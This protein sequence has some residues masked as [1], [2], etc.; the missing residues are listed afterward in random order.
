MAEKKK[1]S[2]KTAG[3]GKA[4]AKAAGGAAAIPAKYFKQL[5]E[6]PLTKAFGVGGPLMT[7]AGL[8]GAGPDAMASLMNALGYTTVEEALGVLQTAKREFVRYLGVPAATIDAFVETLAKQ[9]TPIPKDVLKAI[10]SQTYG[11]GL[12]LDEAHRSD[13][14]PANVALLPAVRAAGAGGAGAPIGLGGGPVGLVGDAVGG[15]LPPNINLISQLPNPVRD[16]NPRQTCVPHGTLVAY[17]HYL[18]VTSNAVDLSEQFLWW[19]CKQRDGIPP[20]NDINGTTMAAAAD[21]LEQVGVCQES[22]WP[23]VN[24]ENPNNVSQGPPPPGAGPDAGNFRVNQVIRV[25]PTAVNDYKRILA[26]GRCVAF[27]VPVYN[28]SFNPQAPGQFGQ[29][30]ATSF[31][32]GKITLPVQ[33][34]FPIGGHC[35]CM[36]G[37]ED[38]TSVPALGGGRFIIRNSFGSLWGSSSKFAAEFGPGY[39]TIPYAY[40]AG[41]ARD[42]GIAFL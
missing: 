39:G 4:T 27:A 7:G 18:S 2:K 3:K 13:R 16:Q 35:M 15:A 12:V 31:A 21:S 20:P 36:V 22:L 24:A 1:S 14:A 6:T 5:P 11:F 40:V 23:Y 33:G 26:S 17:E 42:I 8:V 29:W 38:D 34:E 19:A 30:A 32:T 9:A 25:S 10:T 41:Q 28:S 37:Y